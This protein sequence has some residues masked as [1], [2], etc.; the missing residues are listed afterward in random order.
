M[1][2]NRQSGITSRQI[3]KPSHNPAAAPDGRGSA[4]KSGIAPSGCW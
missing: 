2:L 3:E 4:A 1:A